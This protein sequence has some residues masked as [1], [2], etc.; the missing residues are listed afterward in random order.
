MVMPGVTAQVPETLARINT[1]ERDIAA[2]LVQVSV[3]Q[4][5]LAAIRAR[6]ELEQAQPAAACLADV[7]ER[8]ERRRAVVAAVLALAEPLRD[9]VLLRFYEGLPPREIARRLAV[10]VETA[11][12]RVKRGVEQV[13]ARLTR[14]V[15][16]VRGSGVEQAVVFSHGHALRALT[17]CWLGLDLAV[18]DR[19]PL[20]TSTVSILG[21]AKGGP[22]LEK[23]NAPP[24]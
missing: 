10:P 8:E 6:V 18:G 14:V 24:Q 19:F 13:R 9:A 5:E 16:R 1:L 3:L 11:R 12:T 23:W 2:K 21:E 15:Q 22:A 4:D 7:V 20:D 17:L